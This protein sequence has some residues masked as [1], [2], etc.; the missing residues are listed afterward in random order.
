[1]LVCQ[2]ANETGRRMISLSGRVEHLSGQNQPQGASPGRKRVP[3][4]DRG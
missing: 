1:M 3:T 2:A 4:P